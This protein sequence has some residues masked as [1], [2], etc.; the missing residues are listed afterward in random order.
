MMI[1]VLRDEIKVIDQTHG[2]FKPRMNQ[3]AATKRLINPI[4]LVHKLASPIPKSHQNFFQLTCIVIGLV[5]F[6][7]SQIR[8]SQ[9]T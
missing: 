2:L 8:N 4:K 6:P 3:G 1:V 9:L 7:V 5:R